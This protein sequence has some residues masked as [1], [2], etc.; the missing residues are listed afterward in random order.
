MARRREPAR[1]TARGLSRWNDHEQYSDHNHGF[2]VFG[3]A[4]SC[5][6][7]GR[8]ARQFRDP[9]LANSVLRNARFKKKRKPQSL[10]V[11]L[12]SAPSGLG[13]KVV[14]RRRE[15]AGSTKAFSE[16]VENVLIAQRG[17]I[18]KRHRFPPSFPVALHDAPTIMSRSDRRL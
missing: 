10:V 11:V 12:L 7:G 1:G 8:A 3:D 5:L 16:P 13:S 14:A 2:A 17:Q 9:D 15:P 6:C 4:D 18:I